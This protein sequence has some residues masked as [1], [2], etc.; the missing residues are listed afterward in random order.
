VGGL[1]IGREKVW[2]LTDDIILV[3]KEAANL[4]EM[5]KSFLNLVKKEL[6]LA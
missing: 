2:S 6:I 3:A 5:L 4:K 1:I